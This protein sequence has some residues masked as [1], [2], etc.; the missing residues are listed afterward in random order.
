MLTERTNII[1]DV[2]LGLT[3]GCARC[4]NHKLEPI[5][6]KDYYRLQAFFAA[7]REHNISLASDKEVS[8]WNDATRKIQQQ[9]KALQMRANQ[10]S[11]GDE[12]RVR[13]QIVDLQSRLPPPLPTVPTI[14]NDYES[15]TAVHVLRRGVWEHKGIAVGPRPPGILISSGEA[16]LP[17]DLEDPRTRLARWLADAR[18][19]LTPRVLV[20]RV[21]QHHFGQG[22]VRTANDFGTRGDAPSH[23]ELL[24]W[25]AAELIRT[26]WR[27]KPLHRQIVLSSTYR[28]ASDRSTSECKDAHDADSN[29]SLSQQPADA[30]ATMDPTNRFLWHFSRR[31]LSA[32][33]IRDGMLAVSD[34]LNLRMGGP[35]VIVPVDPELVNLLYKPEQWRVTPDTREHDRRTVYLIAKRNLR[36]PFLEAFDSPTLQ[37]SCSQRTTSTHA[38]QALALLNGP[39]A[40]EMARALADRLEREAG[41]R[42]NDATPSED[43]LPTDNRKR[44]VSAEDTRQTRPEWIVDRAFHLALGRPPNASELRLSLEF[45]REQPLSEFALAILNLNGFVYVP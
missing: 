15:Q 10:L 37:S 45:V 39:F 3:V 2:F 21:W 31:R 25:L 14:R 33:E 35:S 42:S 11:G 24:D 34:R 36:L 5:S 28:Q 13:R 41:L 38:P 7:T 27:L 12:A 23:P 20:N 26:G 30:P 9:L 16:E 6:Q 22:L 18:N 40:N 1:G 4:H 44:A 32:E 43:R 29:H 17:A 8:A 19:P